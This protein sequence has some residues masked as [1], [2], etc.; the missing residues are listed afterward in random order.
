MIV[1]F[2]S[3]SSTSVVVA[4]LNTIHI[5]DPSRESFKMKIVDVRE[6]SEDMPCHGFT[7]D[8]KSSSRVSLCPENITSLQ[9]FN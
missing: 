1:S 6:I 4:V 9:T 7:I 8:T 2:C 5:L 3:A